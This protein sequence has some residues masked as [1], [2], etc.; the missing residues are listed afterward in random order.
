MG[1][2]Y[3]EAYQNASVNV[4]LF[5]GPHLSGRYTHTFQ[6]S[7]CEKK[8]AFLHLRLPERRYK[9]L[10][11]LDLPLLLYN[12]RPP[13]AYVINGTQIVPV[14]LTDI[15]FPGAFIFAARRDWR[16]I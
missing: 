14:S 11:R 2:N 9:F 13:F 1:F 16:D 4:N 10:W 12:R 15:S 8:L 5:S 6:R 7:A 3:N